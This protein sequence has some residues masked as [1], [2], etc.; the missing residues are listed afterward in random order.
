LLDASATLGRRRAVALL[1]VATALSLGAE[2]LGTGTGFPFG[3]YEYT[4]LLGYR[5]GGRVPF[6]IPLSWFFMIY[7]ALA[8]TGRL[9]P[10][11]ADWRGRVVWALVAGAILTAWDVAMDPAM[12]SATKHWVWLT[13]GVYFGMPLTN[14]VGWYVTGSA[15]ALAMLSIAPPPAVARDV[16]PGSLPIALYAVNGIMPVALCLR[17]GLWLAGVIGAVAM[18][19]PVALAIRAAHPTRLVACVSS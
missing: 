8:I 10:A 5:I 7:C 13:D 18:A 12:S 14:W 11:R 16:S 2:L 3:A 15:I 17:H 4:T 1:L 19:L 6:P 9:L